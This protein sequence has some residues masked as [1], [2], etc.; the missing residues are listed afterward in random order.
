MTSAPKK[1]TAQ[2]VASS[3]GTSLAAVSRAFRPEA[4]ISEGLRTDILE[5]AA[6]LGYVPPNHRAR[7]EGGTRMY[8]VVV[9]DLRNT[10]YT[11]ALARLAEAAYR[12]NWEMNVFI[13]PEG[14]SVDA[15]LSQVLASGSRAVLLMTVD[16]NSGLAS[17]CRKRGLPT[18][19]FNRVQID[20]AMMAVTSD[21]YGGGR[22]AA[23]R[24][25]DRGR[26]HIAFIGGQLQTSTHLERRRGLLDQLGSRGHALAEDLACDYSYE[27]ALS[28][29]RKLLD[30]SERPDGVFCANDTMA[31]AV[32]DAARE[33]GLV[34]G[35]D[36]GVIGYDDVP[37]SR[38]SSY[39]L[40]TI[41]Q[42]VELMIGHALTML[43]E[44]TDNPNAAGYIQ[45]VPA[46]LVERISG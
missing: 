11:E 22:L 24:L 28:T 2:D 41:S 4:P 31:F 40:T 43:D 13:A 42:Q 30:Q 1:V 14:G 45:I 37:M 18:V 12:D 17:E 35:K 36:L 5:E 44:V 34:P 7:A 16:L 46:A 26:T 21:N 3:V 33:L 10:F 20:S 9:S 8:S 27:A 32:L 29:A 19:L 25:L 6:R 23:D 38:W 39:Q 15:L